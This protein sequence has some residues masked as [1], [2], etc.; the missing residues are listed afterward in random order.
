M[1][2]IQRHTANTARRDTVFGLVADVIFSVCVNLQAACILC[3]NLNISHMVHKFT[4]TY[5]AR[6]HT[7]ILTSLLHHESTMPTR[8]YSILRFFM[9]DSI[10]LASGFGPPEVLRG[11]TLT[12]ALIRSAYAVTDSSPILK[13]LRFSCTSRPVGHGGGG[14][15]GRGPVGLLGALMLVPLLSVVV[16]T[17]VANADGVC[18]ACF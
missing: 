16:V 8:A 11:D 10:A 3:S 4:D 9:A 18:R 14:G 15:T 17:T 6:L 13:L 5:T 7:L 2:T 12:F 1:R